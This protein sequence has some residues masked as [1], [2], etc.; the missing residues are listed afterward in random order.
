MSFR[1]LFAFLL[2][3]FIA[4]AQTTVIDSIQSGGIWR[5]YRLHLPANY[6]AN[7]SLRPL[8]LNLHG[9]GSNALEQEFYGDFRSIADTAGFLIVH[10]NGTTVNGFTYWNVGLNPGGAN[11]VS[12]LSALIDTLAARY[13]VDTR[14]V[15]SAG[16]S[17]GGIMSYYLA[18][19]LS[20][21]IAAIASVTG[22]ITSNGFPPPAPTH[23]MPVMQIHGTADPVVPYNGG[24]TTIPGV[25]SVTIDT[26]VKFWVTFN[27]CAPS[28]QAFSIPNISTTDGCTA[29]RFLYTGGTSSSTVE[30]FK[31]TGGGH[32]WPGTPFNNMAGATN[33]DF[34]ASAEIWRFFRQYNLGTLSVTNAHARSLDLRL[35]PNPARDAVHIDGAADGTAEV[36]DMCGRTVL[37]VTGTTVSLRTLS[38]GTYTLR[39]TTTKGSSMAVFVKE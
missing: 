19:Y 12:F 10:P 27:G 29:E 25:S 9:L 2:L 31:V 28:P 5:N 17:N 11:D 35:T 26:V 34:N 37:S 4:K 22:S 21:K 6:N 13:R 24:P 7:T 32:T 16:M 14:R 36:M 33:Q 38:A 39:Y 8:I 30:F 18:S 15:F 20:Q 23:P 3:P 1:L